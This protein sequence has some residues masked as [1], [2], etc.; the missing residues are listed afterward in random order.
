MTRVCTG[1]YYVYSSI[2]MYELSIYMYL[3]CMY[4]VSI[5]MS[6]KWATYSGDKVSID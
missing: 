5:Q 1:M 4:L 2:Y 6:W 3:L